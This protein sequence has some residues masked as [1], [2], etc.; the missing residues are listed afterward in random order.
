MLTAE[1]LLQL[2]KTLSLLDNYGDEYLIKHKIKYD[3]AQ[4]KN[5]KPNTYYHATGGTGEI[6]IGFGLY[7]GKDK[8]ALSNFYN[9][10]G[11][12]IDIYEGNPL[13][14]D[15]ALL[16][17]F[18]NFEEEARQKFLNYKFNEHFKMLTLSKRYDGI[19]YYDPIATGEEFV[20]YNCEKLKLIKKSNHHFK[21][22]VQHE[23]KCYE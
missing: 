8:R 6:G 9:C 12:E 3:L 22:E 11:G 7:L 14:I 18:D 5:Y 2:P 16:D 23:R 19:R 10:E 20:V 15:L 21:N 13:F 1:E 4:T 17:D